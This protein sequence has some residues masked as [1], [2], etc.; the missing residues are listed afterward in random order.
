MSKDTISIDPFTLM[1]RLQF[2]SLFI[3]VYESFEDYIRDCPKNFLDGTRYISVE[4]PDYKALCSAEKERQQKEKE[5]AKAFIN[6]AE[7]NGKSISENEDSYICAHFDYQKI[8]VDGMTK[9]L[10]PKYDALI[11]K[12][13]LTIKGKK[14]VKPNVL[15]NSLAFFGNVTDADLEMFQQIKATRNTFAHNMADLLLK[16]VINDENNMLFSKLVNLYI[17]VN[18]YWSVNFECGITNDIP[19][20]ADYDKIITVKLYNLLLAI[21]ALIGTSFINGN[22]YQHYIGLY[23]ALMIP[24]NEEATPNEQSQQNEI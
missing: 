20:N 10:T 8:T 3:A 24:I 1:Q 13:I 11:K 2:M 7:K 22:N 15:L 17:K 5:S 12:R 21:D 9:W 18:N 23:D 16:N 6:N 14:Q 19:D 4:A